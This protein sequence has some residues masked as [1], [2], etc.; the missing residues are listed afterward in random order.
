[1][2]EVARMNS[3]SGGPGNIILWRFSALKNTTVYRVSIAWQSTGMF[4]GSRADVLTSRPPYH[5]YLSSVKLSGSFSRQKNSA[6]RLAEHKR[7]MLNRKVY[8]VVDVFY[9]LCPHLGFRFS[10]I[11]FQNHVIPSLKKNVRF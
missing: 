8:L 3:V 9:L 2:P 1:M 5:N 7:S 4:R 11:V 6:S 10:T